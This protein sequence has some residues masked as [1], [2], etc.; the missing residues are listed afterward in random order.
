ML[1]IT[2]I[3]SHDSNLLNVHFFLSIFCFQIFIKVLNEND[4]V[5]LTLEPVYYTSVP[6]D[7]AGGKF[8]V[9]IEADDADNDPNEILSYRIASGNAEGF[10][11]IN[12][13]TGKRDIY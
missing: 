12:S 13:T 10:F 5:P 9:K 1:L 3:N 2:S 6:E 11:S 4:N 8:V 7:S